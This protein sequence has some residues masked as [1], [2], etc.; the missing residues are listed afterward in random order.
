ML[1][2]IF[3]LRTT[4][5]KT[6]LYNNK[7]W[8]VIGQVYFHVM[9]IQLTYIYTIYIRL[10]YILYKYVYTFIPQMNFERDRVVCALWLRTH[11]IEVFGHFDLS[12]MLISSTGTCSLLQ[13]A[14]SR[15]CFHSIRSECVYHSKFYSLIRCPCLFRCRHFYDTVRCRFLCIIL[16]TTFLI[17]RWMGLWCHFIFHIYRARMSRYNISTAI[18]IETNIL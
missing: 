8:M 9:I 6:R 14:Q 3:T 11:L 13:T 15:F 10:R 5:Q 1:L 17:N 16:S 7:Q 2:L 18:L 4:S 12:S